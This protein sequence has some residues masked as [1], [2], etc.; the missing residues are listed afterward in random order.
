MKTKRFYI[1]TGKG[2]VGKTTLSFSFCQYL[3]AQ[4]IKTRLIY[5]KS[6]LNDEFSEYSQHFNFPVLGLEMVESLKFYIGKK[7]KSKTIASWI[8][9]APLFNALFN[10]I[11]GFNYMIF[12]GQILNDLEKD[13]NLVIVLDSPSS[14][15]ALTM[16][17][18]TQNFSNIFKSGIVFE[19]TQK[20]LTLLAQPN[21]LGI[22]IVSLP[23]QLAISEAKELQESFQALGSYPSTICCNNSLSKLELTPDKI[24]R[25]L[26]EK[27]NN[28]KEALSATELD[29]K[30]I[31]PYSMGKSQLDIIKELVPLMETLV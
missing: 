24:P 10:M 2:G 11:P 5:F 30:L 8:L 29:E 26:Q 4:G 21:H 27:L 17:E 6:S 3:H 31:L 7:L 28:E 20:M 18:A 22:N 12:L 13:P 14:G 15:H 23:S 9:K 1:I 16:L 25:F 19:D